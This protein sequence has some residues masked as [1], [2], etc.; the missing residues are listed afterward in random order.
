M[1][2]YS[3]FSFSLLI[4]MF[5]LL[6]IHR[7]SQ[8]HIVNFMPSS[9]L[10]TGNKC[11]VG[12]DQAAIRKDTKKVVREKLSISNMSTDQQHLLVS[13]L[14]LL[15]QWNHDTTRVTAPEALSPSSL[16]KRSREE[17]T[18]PTRT[19]QRLAENSTPSRGPQKRRKKGKKVG[20]EGPWKWTDP[21]ANNRVTKACEACILLDKINNGELFDHPAAAYGK[22]DEPY[23]S[24]RI[25]AYLLRCRVY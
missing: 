25:C 20:I 23:S 6:I 8:I 22:T 19:S 2:P 13:V 15:G 14:L 10:H 12:V 18:S 16:R 21:G 7:A 1:V 24:S 3:P 5:I 11:L 4:K 17:V 9:H